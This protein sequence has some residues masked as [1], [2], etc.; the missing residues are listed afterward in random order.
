[1]RRGFAAVI[2]LALSSCGGGGESPPASAPVTLAPAPVLTEASAAASSVLDA[3]TL[4]VEAG[5]TRVTFD[6]SDLTSRATPYIVGAGTHFG[7]DINRGY[8]TQ[9]SAAAITENSVTS[10]RDDILW[11]AFTPSGDLSRG[12]IPER[13]ADFMGATTAR[14]LLILNAGHPNVPGGNPPVTEQGRAA[15][16][17]FAG[18][19]ASATTG[20][21]AMYEIWNEW[22]LTAQPSDNRLTTAGEAGD[23]RASIYY[24]PLA[25][26]AAQAIKAEQPSA[27][28]LVGASADDPN[29]NWTTDIVARGALKQ[30]DGLSVH[31][32]NHC[33]SPARRTP[34]EMIERLERLRAAVTPLNGG[35][36]PTIYVTEWGWPT[37][38]GPCSVD[39]AAVRHSVPQ[40]L[41]YTAAL[42]WLGGSWFYELKDSGSDANNIQD[43]FGLNDFNYRPKSG[44]CGFAEAARLIATAKAMDVQEIGDLILIRMH[45]TKGLAI[46]AWSKNSSQTGRITLGG[47][48]PFTARTMCS[49]DSAANGRQ[50]TFGQMPVIIDVPGLSRLAANV[51]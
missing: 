12:R 39:P 10:F 45:T 49:S 46:A 35:R 40:F 34:F 3:E 24:A 11:G 43:N 6:A 28:V 7:L 50:V 15:F 26:M 1:M 22:N 8:D 44:Q 33:E 38:T 19:V 41:L 25:E 37:G 13:I 27:R 42:P 16:A 51:R 4:A 48:A 23:H 5:A 2:C 47:T 20:R 30:A 9:K 14:P 29:W 36:S 17:A 21:E 18:R 32:Y 31:L